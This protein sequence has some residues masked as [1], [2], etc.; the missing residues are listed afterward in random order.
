MEQIRQAVERAKEGSIAGVRQPSRFVASRPAH[1]ANPAVSNPL[2]WSEGRVKEVV[3]RS[4]HLEAHRIVSH[5][6]AHPMRKSFDIL[7]TQ[8][9]QSMDVKDWQ[10]LAVTSPTAGCGKSVT[11][12]NLALSIA[13]Q[14][15]R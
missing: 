1:Q 14:P 3:L 11:A 9:L 4:A 12:I 6:L 15:M 5:D 10:V 7:R 13:R 2:D 8:V